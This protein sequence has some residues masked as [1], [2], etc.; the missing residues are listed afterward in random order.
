MSSAEA[1]VI[2]GFDLS[3]KE[4]RYSEELCELMD[5]TG[6]VDTRYSGNGDCQFVGTELCM[7][8]EYSS[9]NFDKIVETVRQEVSKN[10]LN[11]E[12]DLKNFID[13]LK[14]EY[15]TKELDIESESKEE[16][17]I[18]IAKVEKV[19]TNLQP[20]IVWGST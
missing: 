16:L 17:D 19:M 7:F 5:N 6:L 15:N 20:I 9:V 13:L 10:I 14:D 2:L 12:R 4:D 11:V 3:F 8:N 1:Y 18:F